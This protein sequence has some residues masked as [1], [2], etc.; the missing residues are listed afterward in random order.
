MPPTHQTSYD[1][2]PYES[3]PIA[4]THPD[5]LWTLAHL[6]GIE[7]PALKTCRILELGCGAGGNIIP[8]ACELPH[9]QVVGIDLSSVQ[10]AQGVAAVE[11]LQLDNIKLIAGSVM[12]VDDS[13]G[14]FDYIIAKAS[15]PGSQA[16]CRRRFWRSAS[17]ICLPVAWPT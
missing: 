10:I 14:Q 6:P 7:S 3:F 2:V 16:K 4:G 9:A 5:R 15:T 12:E 13:Y 11:A 1:E 8:I 17:G